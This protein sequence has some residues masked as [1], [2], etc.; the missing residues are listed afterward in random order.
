MFIIKRTAVCQ[1]RSPFGAGGS[2]RFGP[3]FAGCDP[4]ETDRPCQLVLHSTDRFVFTYSEGERER[5]ET[6]RE[7]HNS[8]KEGEK[9]RN[10]F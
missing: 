6:E 2:A 7:S 3:G 9:I 4:Q 1:P 8:K 5:E 10:I